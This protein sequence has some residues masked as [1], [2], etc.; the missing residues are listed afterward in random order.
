MLLL[1]AS[2]DKYFCHPQGNKC[3]V[4][5]AIQGQSW[6]VGAHVPTRLGSRA[7]VGV[8]VLGRL[9]DQDA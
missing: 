2:G 9:Q 4:E 6:K 7:A 5:A 3:R 8:G 1:A